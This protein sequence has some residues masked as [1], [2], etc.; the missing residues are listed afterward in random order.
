MIHLT[1]GQK[2]KGDENVRVAVPTGDYNETDLIECYP[3]D[4]DANNPSIMY[5]AQYI[6]IG[7][8]VYHQSEELTE[9]QVS[10]FLAGKSAD[11]VINNRKLMD[12]KKPAAKY[13]GQVVKRDGRM[14]KRQL[15]DEVQANKVVE[16]KKIDEVKEEVVEEKVKDEPVKDTP[17]ENS[18]ATTT[19]PVTN[20]PTSTDTSTTTPSF[21]ATSTP[22]DT[23]T[24][25]STST[26]ADSSGQVLGEMSTS[27]P[28]FD[29]VNDTTVVPVSDVSTTT[30]G[31]VESVVDAIS[32]I[33]PEI[34]PNV[35][36]DA[37]S[38]TTSAVKT[39]KKIIATARKLKR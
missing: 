21:N 35:I 22:S 6:A 10:A 5:Q 29:I 24:D 23:L 9:D 25:V 12:G 3:S 18:N 14:A 19:T 11:E 37:T 36:E 30:P 34:V 39:V 28:N 1:Q 8:A 27:T 32:D 16:E 20:T 17:V 4:G 38:S 26:P 31:V 33:V 13:L 2:L 7:N 15:R